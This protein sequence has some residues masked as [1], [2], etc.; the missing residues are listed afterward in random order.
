MI[1]VHNAKMKR[2]R[3]GVTNA[4]GRKRKREGRRFRGHVSGVDLKGVF[5]QKGLEKGRSG[6][7]SDKHGR[8]K[9]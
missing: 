6:S 3:R 4:S 2:G 5:C 8:E 9:S 7:K 1:Q